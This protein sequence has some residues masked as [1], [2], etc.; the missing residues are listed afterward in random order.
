MINGCVEAEEGIVDKYIGDSVMSFWNAPTSQ[1]DHALRGVRAACAIA[2]AGTS[3]NRRRESDGLAP[4]RV[5]ICAHS[6]PAV[7]GS[8]ASPRRM[9]HPIAAATAKPRARR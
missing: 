4:L 8:S 7:V 9:N 3:D 5:R 1:K 6:A 2:G